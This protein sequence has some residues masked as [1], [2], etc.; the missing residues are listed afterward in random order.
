MSQPAASRQSPGE[1][2]QV[3]VPPGVSPGEQMHVT[4]PSGHQCT[5]VVPAGA[6]PNSVLQVVVP[7]PVSY[8]LPAQGPLGGSLGGLAGASRSNMQMMSNMMGGLPML[9]PGLQLPGDGKNP[10]SASLAA[11]AISAR[12]G[13][14]PQLQG[15]RGAGAQTY[16]PPGLALAAGRGRQNKRKE[17]VPRQKSAYNLFMKTEVV[18]IK[19]E[20]PE[21]THTQAFAAA[22][23]RWASVKPANLGGVP[24][25]AGSSGDTE[26]TAEGTAAPAAEGAAAESSAEAGDAAAKPDGDGAPETKDSG[27]QAAEADGVAGGGAEAD[28]EH[29]A[30]GE[31]TAEA[32][33]GE[34]VEEGAPDAKRAKVDDAGAETIDADP[35]TVDGE[36]AT[37]TEEP[38]V[39]G[40]DTASEQSLGIIDYPADE[41]AQSADGTAGKE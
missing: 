12:Y 32:D 29:S 38:E 22:A 1:V 37:A 23:R 26:S 5:V 30:G 15:G 34:E 28:R 14:I 40:G 17:R 3:Q 10:S 31:N 39:I 4:L 18:R 35:K 11:A 36:P 20:K 25:T 24:S 9:P 13:G 2:H 41:S 33:V 16:V 6:G 7:G 21:L 27:S 19:K 8:N